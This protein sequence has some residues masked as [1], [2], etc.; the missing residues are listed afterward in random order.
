MLQEDLRNPPPTITTTTTTTITTTTTTL[1]VPMLGL[2]WL[3]W[4]RVP[5]PIYPGSKP[6]Q[7]HACIVVLFHP[8]HELRFAHAVCCVFQH[9]PSFLFLKATA[10]RMHGTDAAQA[11]TKRSV[12][13]PAT[14]QDCGCR[15]LASECC[16]C[17]ATHCLAR[18]A[19]T[20]SQQARLSCAYIQWFPVHATA[21]PGASAGPVAAYTAQLSC[22]LCITAA[23]NAL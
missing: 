14:L 10:N 8:R 16:Y 23:V 5:G 22:L 7:L 13:Q 19:A 15:R 9:G 4:C 18:H 11:S 17:R 2:I 12:K 1:L 21:N 20:C 3:R 6:R